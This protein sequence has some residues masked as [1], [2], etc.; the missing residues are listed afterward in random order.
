[1][2]LEELGKLLAWADMTKNDWKFIEKYIK[3]GK[4]KKALEVFAGT[5]ISKKD[6]EAAEKIILKMETNRYENCNI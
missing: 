2:I 3:Q 4:G 6:Y 1:M 5:G